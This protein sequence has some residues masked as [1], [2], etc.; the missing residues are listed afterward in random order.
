MLNKNVHPRLTGVIENLLL[1]FEKG[2]PFFGEVCLNINFIKDEKIPTAGVNIG[3][4]G[5]NFYYNPKFVEERT[6]KELAFLVFHELFHLLFS[7]HKR[8]K[9]GGYDP[10]LSNVAQDACINEIIL[11]EFSSDDVEFIEGGIRRPKGYT[12]E[13]IFEEVYEFLK[14]K[15]EEKE[16]DAKENGGKGTCG[17]ED[18]DKIFEQMD[19]NGG[20]FTDVHLKDEI[21]P[22]LK[23]TMVEEMVSKIKARGQMSQKAEGILGKLRRKRKDYLREI[24]KKVSSLIGGFAKEKTFKKINRRQISGIKGKKKVSSAINCILDTSGSMSGEFDKVMSY[25]FQNDIMINLIQCDTQVQVAQKIS[26]KKQLEKVK[27]KGLGG[28]VLMPAVKEV[29]EKYSKLNTLILTD[30]YTDT[31]DFTGI[32]G[33]ILILSTQSKCPTKGGNVK[34]VIIEKD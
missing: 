23:E 3:Y 25:I 24:K 31:L 8:V 22:E 18:L 11:D 13:L 17:D 20:Q 30:G 29:K 15:K 7:H 27:I 19:A 12:G 32:K 26:D 1:D 28:T 16:D 5:M 21:S 6:D 34:Q 33:K 4:K 9:M 2:Y 10:T 14:E